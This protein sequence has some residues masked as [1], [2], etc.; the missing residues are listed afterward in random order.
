MMFT[1]LLNF[2]FPPNLKERI[3]AN[4]L[5]N[6]APSKDSGEIL[7]FFDYND[8]AVKQLIWSLKYKRKKESAKTLA[9]VLHEYLLEEIGD[10]ELFEDFTDPLLIPIPLSKQRLRERGYNQTELIAVELS[11]NNVYKL[12][13][14]CLI[15]IKNTES[16]TTKNKEERMEN[17]KNAFAV[18]NKDLIQNKNIILLDDVVTTGSTLKEAKETLLKNGA[19]NVLAIAVAH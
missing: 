16:Q 17:L 19:K 18:R 3:T 10:L 8:K 12:N 1:T 15:R 14:K 5:L 11:K 2:L 9:E 7:S 13:T 6:R 4:D